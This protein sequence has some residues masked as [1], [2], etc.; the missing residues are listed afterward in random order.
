MNSQTIKKFGVVRADVREKDRKEIIASRTGSQMK[1]VATESLVVIEDDGDDNRNDIADVED[2]E[3]VFA[4]E[5]DE[6]LE[7]ASAS[8]RKV[9]TT[10][11]GILQQVA[12]EQRDEVLLSSSVVA[13]GGAVSEVDEEGAA[14]GATTR[15][16]PAA[17]GSNLLSLD[18]SPE[19]DRRLFRIKRTDPILSLD[20]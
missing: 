1:G 15:R 7:T 11:T 9:F 3:E 16:H 18:Q 5:D 13:D 17:S 10:W 2:V 20:R 14:G 6:Q 12:E 8:A 19:L 4:V